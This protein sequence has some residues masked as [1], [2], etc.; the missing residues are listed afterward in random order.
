VSQS[1]VVERAVE[2]GAIFANVVVGVD[3]SRGSAEAA[4]QAIGLADSGT[5]VRFVAIHHEL[6]TDLDEPT[7][8]NREKA[9]EALKEVSGQAARAGIEFSSALLSGT[10]VSEVLRKEARDS[11][12]LALGSS[13]G[14]RIGGIMLGGTVTQIAHRAEHPLLVARRATDNGHFPESILLASDGSPGSWAAARAAARLVVARAAELRVVYVSNGAHTERHRQFLRQLMM[15]EEL[16]GEIPSIQDKPGSVPE[17]ICQ[18][19]Q[20]FQAS[21]IVMGRRALSGIAAL[22]GVSERVVHRAPCSVLVLPPDPE[23]EQH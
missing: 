1:S 3:G 19:A 6:E 14:T 9:Q 22:G 15:L 4:R 21:V 23:D 8:L 10:R 11:D 13:G 18:A 12:L 20:G 17:R 16:C 2:P 7:A 5:Q